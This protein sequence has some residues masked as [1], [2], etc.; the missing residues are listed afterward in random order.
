MAMPIVVT[1]SNHSDIS[2]FQP[3]EIPLSGVPD[4]I[5]NF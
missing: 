5:G 3:A 4:A 2:R 1:Q